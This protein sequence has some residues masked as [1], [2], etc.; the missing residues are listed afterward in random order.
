MFNHSNDANIELNIDRENNLY[1]LKTLVSY[2]KHEQVFIKYGFHCN[3]KLFVEYGF[4]LPNNPHDFVEFTFE[5]II[6]YLQ[7]ENYS[8]GM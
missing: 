2:K 5:E 1:I 7:S 4:V 3:F 8:C 6:S